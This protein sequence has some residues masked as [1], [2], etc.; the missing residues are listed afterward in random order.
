MRTILQLRIRTF[1]I[2][3]PVSGKRHGFI[4][5]CRLYSVSLLPCF[6]G[7]GLSTL[8]GC[9]LYRVF[10]HNQ[11]LLAYISEQN[12]CVAVGTLTRVKRK[13]F[14]HNIMFRKEKK[15]SFR[16]RRFP[17]PGTFIRGDD[18]SMVTALKNLT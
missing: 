15:K 10:R 12:Y 7:T 6:A 4:L 16:R 13:I 14:H 17:L 8:S 3:P 1:R 5:G 2:I 9:N 11:N 18:S